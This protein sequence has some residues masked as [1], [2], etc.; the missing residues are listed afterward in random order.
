MKNS[1]EHVHQLAEIAAK[2]D[3]AGLSTEAT[4][5]DRF[6]EKKADVLSFHEKPPLGNLAKIWMYTVLSPGRVSNPKAR[7]LEFLDGTPVY[8]MDSDTAFKKL[9]KDL[10][11]YVEKVLVPRLQSRWTGTPQEE[12]YRD[13]VESVTDLIDEL[14]GASGAKTSLDQV[15]SA[16]RS[17][18][19]ALTQLIINEPNSGRKAYVREVRDKAKRI[20]DTLQQA[21][22]KGNVEEVREQNKQLRKLMNQQQ[23]DLLD[24]IYKSSVEPLG[25]RRKALSKSEIEEIE[26][27]HKGDTSLANEITQL[28]KDIEKLDEEYAYWTDQQTSFNTRVQSFW[29]SFRNKAT[30][31]AQVTRTYNTK[32]LGSAMRRIDEDYKFSKRDT[33]RNHISGDDKTKIRQTLQDM[34]RF[35]T[36]YEEYKKDDRIEMASSVVGVLLPFSYF[37]GHPN[38]DV[39]KMWERP[40]KRNQHR[41]AN[42]IQQRRA[43]VTLAIEEKKE[44]LEGLLP[45]YEE[46]REAIPNKKLLVYDRWYEKYIDV[47]TETAEAYTTPPEDVRESNRDVKNR[48]QQ[49]LRYSL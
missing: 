5:I 18:D 24:L 7:G 9:V 38:K 46:E 33:P 30:E 12:R 14:K 28:N 23:Q 43:D 41:A 2:L 29:E 8:G 20:L 34:D 19:W 42:I 49:L 40:V 37:L 15:K 13:F 4:L 48:F 6:L 26:K 21:V 10:Q 31:Q 32:G 47:L 17:T 39:F 45:S 1:M 35:D 25:R 11:Q 3:S 16:I 27:E 22:R 36:Y 44:Q